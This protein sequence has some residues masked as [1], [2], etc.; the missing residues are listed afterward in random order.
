MVGGASLGISIVFSKDASKCATRIND[1]LYETRMNSMSKAGDY[2]LEIKNN[3][4]A[5]VAVISC[6]GADPKTIYLDD[7]QT[8]TK[9]DITLEF[10]LEDGTILNPAPALPVKIKFDKAKGN[11]SIDG[12]SDDGILRFKIMPRRGNRDAKVQLV[13]TTGKHT[14][15]EFD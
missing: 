15:G 1:A 4:T 13:T 12:I 10:E 9:T 7:I 2:T 11:A 8:D 6:T 14:I 3:G 5:N